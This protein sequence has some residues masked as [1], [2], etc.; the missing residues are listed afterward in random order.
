MPDY[1]PL[2]APELKTLI[3]KLIDE[4]LVKSGRFEPHISYPNCQFWF[5]VNVHLPVQIDRDF[6]IEKK[7]EREMLEEGQPADTL[8]VSGELLES[9]DNPPDRIR[10]EHGLPVTITEIGKGHGGMPTIVQREV[11]RGPRI[12]RE[13]KGR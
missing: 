9:Q 3:L 4:E 2:S 12:G 13:H 7:I 8:V 5:S 10:D 6:K 11:V 1:I